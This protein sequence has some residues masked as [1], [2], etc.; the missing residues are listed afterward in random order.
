MRAIPT[1]DTP[2]LVTRVNFVTFF[3]YNLPP[4]LLLPSSSSTVSKGFLGPL[5]RCDPIACNHEFFV[6]QSR[7]FF[8]FLLLSR[9]NSAI[10]LSRRQSPRP[11][12]LLLGA[13]SNGL[14]TQYMFSSTNYY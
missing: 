2:N 14:T 6:L 10:Q 8:S 4:L 11:Y 7:V 13:D 5:S 12:V 9:D 1:S 3:F